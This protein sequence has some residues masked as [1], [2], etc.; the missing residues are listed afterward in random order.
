MEDDEENEETEGEKKEPTHFS[1]LDP[2]A[3]KVSALLY[4]RRFL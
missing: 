2:K 3:M 1:E 4:Y